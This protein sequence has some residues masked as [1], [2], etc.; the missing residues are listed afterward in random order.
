MVGD[1]ESNGHKYSVKANSD[2]VEIFRE[3]AKI[4]NGEIKEGCKGVVFNSNGV[5]HEFEDKVSECELM[6]NGEIALKKKNC[7]IG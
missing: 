6:V 7:E 1:Y 4:Y 2:I 5:K 3:G